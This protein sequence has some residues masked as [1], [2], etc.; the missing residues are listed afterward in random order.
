[1]PTIRRQWL[2]MPALNGLAGGFAKFYIA[3]VIGLGLLILA[4][5]IANCGI[6]G[7]HVTDQ[8]RFFS[9][10]V[11]ALIGS[12]MKIQLSGVTA[13]MSLNFFFVLT[14]VAQ[15]DLGEAL[16]IGCGGALT[17]C[18]FHP[19]ARLK[20]SQVI[21]SVSG[22]AIAIRLA[23]LVQHAPTLQS[24]LLT[25]ATYYVSNTSLIAV[26]VAL[27]QERNP[28]TVW[29]GSYAWSFPNYL[30]G[31]AGAGLVGF[32]NGIIGWQA[33]LLVL[34]V[35][36]LV[37]R[38]H[39]LYAARLE[40]EKQRA[41]REQEHARE[42]SRLQRNAIETLA[43]A[44]EAKDPNTS[45]HLERVENYSVSIGRELG[46]T[47]EELDAL[48]TAALLHD[49]GKLAV[50]EHIISK[51]GRLTPEEFSVMK[52]HTVV[53]AEVVKRIG[54]PDAVQR[55]VRGH[56]EKWDGTGY[57]D[58]LG[59]T[60]ISMGARILAIVDCLDALTTD[61]QYRRAMDFEAALDVIRRESGKSFD[62]ALVD[63]LFRHS[64]RF[65]LHLQTSARIIDL[66]AREAVLRG[67]APARGFDQPTSP[68]HA[69]FVIDLC[70][71][72]ENLEKRWAGI[73]AGVAAEPMP[74]YGPALLSP[75]RTVVDYDAF[76]IYRKQDNRLVAELV[77][78]EFRDFCSRSIAVG[79]GLSGW[80]AENLQCITNGN[81]Q[82]E[83]GY[84]RDRSRFGSLRSALAV[85]VQYEDRLVGVMSVYSRRD[86][87][88]TMKHLEA[89]Q[90]LA[91]K[92]SAAIM[93]S[94]LSD[95]HPSGC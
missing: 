31:A 40:Q 70:S 89:L 37:H 59:G 42:M 22:V 79:Q 58:G 82:V 16:I 28:W 55:M 45:A 57:P 24:Y 25:A 62:P 35:L 74:A 71:V 1:M 48:G 10:L 56:H 20:A 66:P 54:F 94:A 11:I 80:V 83:P 47:A 51:P 14:A 43:L 63:I 39:R 30:V 69:E 52:T 18:L 92:F 41:D 23:F 67:A 53:G 17:Q 7:R 34:P 44:V 32:L 8:G 5:G 65:R 36:H 86:A 26:V 88:Y 19:K 87:A 72:A 73:S 93:S 29:L 15:F 68:L 38:S 6:W 77:D 9:W 95:T 64:D 33:A 50:P 49:I 85:P 2:R 90:R 81:P 91:E 12:A 3:V 21:F 75:L 4:S 78:G 76:V 46:F 13:T 27:T 60:G 84:E 61:R